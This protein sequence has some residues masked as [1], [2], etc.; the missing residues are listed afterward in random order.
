MPEQQHVVY[1]GEVDTFQLFLFFLPIRL[2]V[3]EYRFLFSH[4]SYH[5]R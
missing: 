2:S 3:S 1:E 5:Q 4:N